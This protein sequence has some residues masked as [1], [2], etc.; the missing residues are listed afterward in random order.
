MHGTISTTAKSAIPF[1]VKDGVKS[2]ADDE[3]WFSIAAR[4]LYP[5]KPGT[6][7]HLITTLG[8]ERLCQKYAAGDVR[9][10]AYFLRALLRSDHG[11]QWLA[12]LMDGCTA[13]WWRDLESA[14][15]LCVNYQ[16]VRRE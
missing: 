6:A 1:G 2:D 8:N 13:G 10:P 7:L 11:E 15:H 12:V 5:V 14:R 4:Q 3:N 16:I 9:P